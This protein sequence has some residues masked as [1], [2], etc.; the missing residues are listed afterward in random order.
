MEKRT[1]EE[2]KEIIEKIRHKD[3]VVFRCAISHL[4]DVGIRVLTDENVK[5][6][7]NDIMERDDSNLIMTNDFQCAIVRTAA[8]L[9]KIDHIHLLVYIQTKLF[10]DVGQKEIQYDRLVKLL[11][12]C[13]EWI[14]EMGSGSE[15]FKDT[16]INACDFETEE[17]KQLGFGYCLTEE[18]YNEEE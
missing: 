11:E 12:N 13:M 15:D 1:Y 8:E 4:M 9:A 17:I 7:C 2:S 5:A 3:E 10:Y 16:L 14:D 6:T 18:E